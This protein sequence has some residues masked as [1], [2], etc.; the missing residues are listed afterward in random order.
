MSRKRIA[1]SVVVTLGL[2]LV[3]AGCGTVPSETVGKPAA[4]PATRAE[5]ARQ[6]NTICRQESA[7]VE[8]LSQDVGSQVADIG[9]DEFASRVL[10]TQERSLVAMRKVPVPPADQ[11]NVSEVIRLQA[12][13][14]DF[15]EEAVDLLSA[16]RVQEGFEQLGAADRSAHR[17]VELAVGLGADACDLELSVDLAQDED[18]GHLLA[19]DFSDP[20][21][22]FWVENEMRGT[23]VGRKASAERI[24]VP[25]R[26]RGASALALLPESKDAVSVAADVT[27]LRSAHAPEVA[28]VSCIADSGGVSYD[29][30]IAPGIGYYAVTRVSARGVRIL[31]EGRAPGLVRGVRHVNKVRGECSSHGHG[32][33][34]SVR[35]FVNGAR[36]VSIRDPK[37]LSDFSAIGLLVY[38]K[39]GGTT[40]EFD[41]VVVDPL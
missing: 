7:E 17:S 28:V 38:S 6:V 33:A 41:N 32:R 16:G 8:A 25:G 19:D 31:K 24:S 3:A 29:F 26:D 35:L 14:N 10:A 13:A 1:A 15:A 4:K 40:A 27:Q 30:A 23:S 22:S 11:A 34:T 21:K 2:G 37:G 5:W 9:F 20:S 39:A 18:S 12:Q 36:L